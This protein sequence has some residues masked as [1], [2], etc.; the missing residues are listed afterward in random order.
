ME[1]FPKIIRWVGNEL[2]KAHVAANRFEAVAIL[3]LLALAL[4][5]ALSFEIAVLVPLL[6]GLF[7]FS[8]FLLVRHYLALWRPL[9]AH[10]LFAVCVSILVIEIA[11]HHY[12][13]LHLNRF[14]LSLAFQPQAQQQIGLSSTLLYQLALVAGLAYLAARFL[15]WR[16][17]VPLRKLTYGTVACLVTAQL[18]YGF[19]LYQRDTGLLNSQKDLVFFAG[20]HHYYAERI[21]TPLFGPR[22][23]NPYARPFNGTATRPAQG[24]TWSVTER[25]N[26]LMV[27]VDS[28]RA[29]DI[30]A[31][32]TLAPNLLELGKRGYL[33]LDHSSVAN[34]TH[35]GMH[36]LLSGELATS[37]GQARHGGKAQG[38]FAA[39]AGAGYRIS[40]TEAQSLDWYDLASIYLPGAE[41]TIAPEGD[42]A[43]RDDYVAAQTVKQL[44]QTKNM[45]GT[46]WAHLAYFTGPH[47]PYDKQAS[48]TADGYR[49][50]IRETD[51]R[52][53]RM[54]HD[55]KAAG[56]LSNTLVI[57]TS[58][59]GEEMFDN[60]TIGH[61]S[62]LNDAQTK[63]P[64]LILG[65][66]V[67]TDWIR[68]H[69]DI[70]PFVRAEMGAAPLRALSRT[71]EVLTG[72]DYEFPQ[73][74][75]IIDAQGRVDFRLHDG[76]LT[77][78]PS[79]D[80]TI[81]TEDQ[82]R[83]SSFKLIQVLNQA[84]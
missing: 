7:L 32:S 17:H 66:T 8:A 43:S 26:L 28:T 52:I 9:A 29:M 54:L 18:M 15:H 76:L 82:V 23:S 53:G 67:P 62:I 57:V 55:L 6:H 21:F 72:C 22:P 38:I 11:I 45:P 20:I 49:A 33:S 50:T 71:T 64:L 10:I 51:R 56:L 16:S 12:T 30:K 60:A 13:S 65:A 40:T 39:L 63:V 74:F 34:C 46:P 78:T 84:D 68:S 59:H 3:F 31:D 48:A 27:V 70:L 79:P 25:R 77:P 35:F 42:S 44:E 41:R 81:P 19:L 5:P 83:R 4:W 14:V 69:R 75:A 47:F 73:S 80:G 2:K 1:T 36:T 37:F 24:K 58:D 61:G